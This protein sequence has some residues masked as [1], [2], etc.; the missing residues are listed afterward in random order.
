MF[1]N[2]GLTFCLLIIIASISCAELVCTNPISGGLIVYS[3]A[4][5]SVYWK[6]GID[7]PLDVHF[8]NNKDIWYAEYGNDRVVRLA[9]DPVNNTWDQAQTVN[10]SDPITVITDDNGALY[11]ACQDQKIWKYEGGNLTHW[12]TTEHIDP[13][14]MAW[15]PK[16]QLW[17]TCNDGNHIEAFGP[18]G[19]SPVMS[20]PLWNVA[21]ITNGPDYN[22]DGVPDMYVNDRRN[23]VHVISGKDMDWLGLAIDNSPLIA[24][25]IGMTYGPDANADGTRDLYI[26]DFTNAVSHIFSGKSPYNYIRMLNNDQVYFI[27]AYPPMP[28]NLISDGY[29][30]GARTFQDQYIVYNLGVNT[31]GVGY[32]PFAMGCVTEPDGGFWMA[33]YN[34]G[35]VIHHTRTSETAWNPDDSFEID[36]PTGVTRDAAGNIYAVSDADNMIYKFDGT[37]VTQWGGPTA[38]APRD[39]AFGPGGKLWVACDDGQALQI[40]ANGSLEQSILAPNVYGIACGPDQTGDGI[41]DMYVVQQYDEIRV[42]DGI[43]GRLW[44]VWSKDPGRLANGL[45]IDCGP[46]QDFDGVPDLYVGQRTGQVGVHVYSGR[47]G[48][49]IRYLNND[50]VGFIAVYPNPSE[51]T[52]NIPATNPN[53]KLIYNYNCDEHLGWY[54]APGVTFEEGFGWDVYDSDPKPWGGRM[55]GAFNTNN[56]LRL[57]NLPAHSEITVTFDLILHGTGGGNRWDGQGITGDP[58]PDRFAVYVDSEV[59]LP[60][61]SFSQDGSLVQTYP[62]V[63]ETVTYPGLTGASR[64]YVNPDNNS[65]YTE[66]RNLTF[67]IP[68]TSSSANIVFAYNASDTLTELYFLDNIR[69]SVKPTPEVPPIVVNTVGEAKN[70]NL[71]DKLALG[72]KAVTAVFSDDGVQSIYIEEDDRSSGIKVYP[73]NNPSVLVGYRVDVTGTL[74]IDDNGE[75]ALVNATVT[76]VNS[77]PYMVQP[78]AMNNTSFPGNGLKSTGL[79]VQAWGSVT[80]IDGQYYWIDDGAGLKESEVSPT[81][82]RVLGDCPGNQGDYVQVAGISSLLKVGDNSVPVLRMRY[83]SDA[84]VA[85]P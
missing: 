17:V 43:T 56:A 7:F 65:A 71:G 49:Y 59:G 41:P 21:G 58:N 73:V 10:V 77:G 45:G 42:H 52:G 8:D 72:N 61:A 80:G 67:T 24:Q 83:P 12:A 48:A 62:F 54:L 55:L 82:L 28:K 44:D 20:T 32:M 47:T 70:K 4:G 74:Q 64:H 40:F 2:L 46:D 16:K 6:F 81:G 38:V 75:L 85:V 53:I 78:L 13:K 79:F 84:V 39:I 9:Y 15:G 25:A 29:V 22:L 14:C 5:P 35:A 68:H 63:H 26:C 76:V 50:D 1:K 36:A 37:N 11:I 66:Y 18:A 69:V 31:I 51:Y 30:L 3:N 19:G 57:R 34:G 27:A 33:T 60:L 23:Y